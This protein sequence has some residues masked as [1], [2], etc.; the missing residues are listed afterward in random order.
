[1]LESGNNATFV[2]RSRYVFFMPPVS[3]D[4]LCIITQCHLPKIISPSLH[5]LS[6]M[7]IFQFCSPKIQL[8]DL[9]PNSLFIHHTSHTTT[10]FPQ[11]TPLKPFSTQN[12]STP[13]QAPHPPYP[14][15]H[16]SSYYQTCVSR[17]NLIPLHKTA[18]ATPYCRCIS[19]TLASPIYSVSRHY[20][21]HLSLLF[22]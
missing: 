22:A 2:D 15:S 10:P 8:Q 19:D 20:A 12:A 17:N 6:I 13:S 3:T 4:Y 5:P 18:S 7:P 9:Y 14:S 21:A 16:P 11:L 1:M